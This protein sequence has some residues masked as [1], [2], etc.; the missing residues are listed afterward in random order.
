M[1]AST[2]YGSISVLRITITLNLGNAIRDIALGPLRREAN[3]A[4][5]VARLQDEWEE[6]KY[7]NKLRDEVSQQVT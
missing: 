6:M 1:R 3:E 2:K 5:E 4:L 7:R